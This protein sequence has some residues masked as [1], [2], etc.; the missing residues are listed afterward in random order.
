MFINGFRI[1]LKLKHFTKLA[2]IFIK[3][4]SLKLIK[5]EV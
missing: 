1:K 3:L 2:L 5:F 4:F